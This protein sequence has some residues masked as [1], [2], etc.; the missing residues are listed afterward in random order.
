MSDTTRTLLI[1][2]GVALLV[3]LLVPA[4][5]MAGM[6][7]AMMGGMMDGWGAWVVVGLILLILVAGTALI[8]IGV[9]RGC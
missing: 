9:F 2:I 1:A 6:M 7:G 5:I 4:L 8:A 3:V